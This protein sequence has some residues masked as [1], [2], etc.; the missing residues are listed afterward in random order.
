MH[1]QS[2]FWWYVGLL[3]VGG[4]SFSPCWWL[5][6]GQCPA[7]IRTKG[8]RGLLSTDRSPSSVEMHD[9]VPTQVASD[10]SRYILETVAGTRSEASGRLHGRMGVHA[11]VKNE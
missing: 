6:W 9:P 7:G 5:F 4:P 1:P 10:E 8:A 11:C 2:I 3:G